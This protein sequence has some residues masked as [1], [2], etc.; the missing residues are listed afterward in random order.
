VVLTGFW[1]EAGGAATPAASLERYVSA[2]HAHRADIAAPL[3]SPA[4]DETSL[5]RQWAHDEEVLRAA[6]GRVVA[7]TPAAADLDPERPFESIQFLPLASG[8]DSGRAAYAVTIVHREQREGTFFGLFPAA[9]QELVEDA[10]VGTIELRLLPR[11]PGS[12]EGLDHVWRIE[13]VSVQAP[14]I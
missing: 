13:S 7:V 2:W 9:R 1:L 3:F 8:A 5:A 14:G 11:G 6:I 10:R 4:Q 12:L